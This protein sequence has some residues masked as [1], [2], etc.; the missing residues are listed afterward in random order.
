MFARI[1][2]LTVFSALFGLAATGAAQEINGQRARKVLGELQKIRAL[3]GDHF[4]YADFAE[5]TIAEVFDLRPADESGRRRNASR[6]ADD[7]LDVYALI[8]GG[9]AIR[10]TIQLDRLRPY[11]PQNC[12]VDP[13]TLAAPE[14]KSHPWHEMLKTRGWR[15]FELSKCAPHD[16]YYL[17]FNNMKNALD[18]FDYADEAGGALFKRFAPVSVDYNLKEKLLTQLALRVT[19][20]ARNFYDSVIEEMAIVGSD[21]FVLEGSDVTVIYRLKKPLVFA[22]TIASY[23]FSFQKTCGAHDEEVVIGGVKGRRLH[24]PDGRVNSYLFVLSDGTA[25][26]SNSPRA[27]ET[28][29]KTANGD[30]QSLNAALDFRYM[31]SIFKADDRSEDAFFYLSDAF[32][33]RLVAPELRIR[34]SRRMAEAVRIAALE[35]YAILYRHMSGKIPAD[36]DELARAFAQTAL[37]AEHKKRI[38]DIVA[39]DEWRV[40]NSCQDRRTLTDWRRLEDHLVQR[41]RDGYCEHRENAAQ[42]VPDD[43]VIRA[44]VATVLAELKALYADV[45]GAP[46]ATPLDAAGLILNRTAGSP[47]FAEFDGLEFVPGSLTVKSR[48][49]GRIGFFTPNLETDLL[50]VSEEEARLYAEFADKYKDYWRDYFDP[51]GIRVKMSDGLKIETCILPLVNNSVYDGLTAASGGRPVTFG[52]GQLTGETGSLYVKFNRDELLKMAGR[53]ADELWQ[54]L[55]DELGMSR[56]DL[57]SIFGNTI[58]VHMLDARPLVDFDPTPLVGLLL[59]SG[60]A[61]RSHVV[62]GMFAVSSMFHPLRLSLAIA[63]EKKAAQALE[64]LDKFIAKKAAGAQSRDFGEQLVIDHYFL[65]HEKSRI[66]VL[67]LSFAHVLNFR[68]YYALADGRLHVTTTEEYIRKVLSEK[69]NRA[70]GRIQGNVRLTFRPGEMVAGRGVYETGIAES[71]RTASFK[72][73]GTLALLGMLFPDER[74]LPGRCLAEFGFKPVSSG[75]T[76]L[77]DRRT[78]DVTDSCFG[79]T[80]NSRLNPSAVKQGA[81]I[82]RFFKI[83]KFD[84]T[85]RFTPEGIMTTVE[86]K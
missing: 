9:L 54:A 61:E 29:L 5:E 75:G 35:R 82:E 45:K 6:R 51:I 42:P 49:Y 60:G 11:R 56:D 66:R 72:N 59:G 22:A 68:F 30:R 7:D 17:H 37:S 77:V 31:R 40:I 58:E 83:A 34:E 62:A 74:D 47:R 18:F 28:I 57:L 13:A 53:E 20:E 48:A 39:T 55:T 65:E 23:R 73:F 8:S 16:F 2:R 81:G 64:C 86:I 46:A 78:F 36:V 80:G 43:A 52:A 50:K 4:G 10:E 27:V 63:D 67:K 33:R 32:I 38:T 69:P 12:T 84:L 79:A 26:I 70:A 25:L 1:F 15:A 19:P 14:I 21:P 71:V 3:G 41:I 85:L 44:R 76:Y 24:S